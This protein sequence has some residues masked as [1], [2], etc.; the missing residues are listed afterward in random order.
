MS[1][2]RGLPFV[3]GATPQERA[4]SYPCDHYLPC[5]Q[6]EFF[7]AIDVDAAPALTY[8]W[9]QQLRVAPY[10]YDWAD[11]FGL[12]SPARLSPRAAQISVGQR[13]MHVFAIL[14][15]E[16]GRTLTLGPRSRLAAALFGEL[17][18]T[19]VVSPRADGGSR[20]FV[21]VN[22]NY[23]RSLYG[24][25]VGGA[26]PWIDLFMMSKQLR[27]LKALAEKTAAADERRLQS[28]LSPERFV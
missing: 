20:L 7:R 17:Y 16:P 6:H 8:R 19:Y 13:M 27:R 3:W 21:K 11:N 4:V 5:A 26:M 10:S 18:G 25:L 28:S 9:L 24:R 14:A 12:P 1:D 15:F 23:P 2:P 22:A